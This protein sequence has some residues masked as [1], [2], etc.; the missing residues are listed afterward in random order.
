MVYVALGH[1]F[2]VI[3]FVGIFLPV[4]PTTPFVILACLCYERGSPRF[5]H[6]LL[7]NKVFGPYIQNWKKNG[8]IPLGAKVFALTMIITSIGYIVY[9][10]PLIPVKVVMAF[11]G[12]SVSLY[13]LTRPTTPQ[14]KRDIN[15]SG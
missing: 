1:T 6:A 11:V 4:L 12:V 2:L 3:G 5:H 9:A 10:A 15:P 8:S 13:I 14:T 7:E